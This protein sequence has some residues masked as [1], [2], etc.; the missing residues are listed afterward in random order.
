MIFNLFKS[1]PILKELIPEGFIDIHSHILP[2]ID[3]GA[4]NVEESTRLIYEMKKLG[5][6]K[7]ICTPHIYPNL[8]D[9]NINSISKSFRTIQ[10]KKLDLKIKYAAEYY[11]DNSIILKAESKEL[12]TLKENFVL[13]EFGFINLH[14]NYL[15]II[16][17]LQLYG[18]KIILAHPE[19]YLYFNENKK[20]IYNLKSKGVYF[21]LNFGSVIGVYGKRV[22][23]LANY[24]I[25]NNLIDFVGSD[26]HNQNDIDL[27][28]KKVMLNDFRKLESIINENNIFD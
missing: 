22:L 6:S 11:I 1:Q 13:I 27:Y 5:F 2:G 7:I 24:M 16:F 14:P 23:D 4:K 10:T 26:I 28:S 15:E 20:V 21:Q 18:Y 17:R 25:K 19:R 8:Y 9:N 12:L 3:D